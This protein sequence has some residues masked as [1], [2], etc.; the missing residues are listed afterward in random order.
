MGFPSLHRLK[1]CHTQQ[2]QIFCPLPSRCVSGYCT[3]G[4]F[5]GPVEYCFGDIPIC[6]NKDIQ[7]N[8]HYDGITNSNY[9]V[10]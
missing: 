8:S 6:S 1:P 5:I 10:V 4:I 3:A 2:D 7:R 9:C